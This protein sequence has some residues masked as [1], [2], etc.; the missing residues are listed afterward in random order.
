MPTKHFMVV[1]DDDMS[2][3]MPYG[4]SKECEGALDN[5]QP[6]AL[7]RSRKQARRA[8]TISKAHAK[9]KKLQGVPFSEDF[10]LSGSLIKIVE[11]VVVEEGTK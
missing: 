10:L 5:A 7:F 4:M 2:L 3:C 11:C 1:F 6:T 8:I 9:L